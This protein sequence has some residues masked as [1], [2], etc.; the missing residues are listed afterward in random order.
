MS[1]FTDPDPFVSIVP[2]YLPEP[3]LLVQ[4]S[5]FFEVVGGLGLL[6]PRLRRAAGWGL[7][8]L[9]VAVYPANIYMLTEDIYLEGMP[10]ARWLLWARMPMQF[11]MAAWVL[12]VAEIWPRPAPPPPSSVATD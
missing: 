11:V 3:L 12:W 9:L 7:L 8:A 6:V 4:V 2:S 10:K 1:H 5:G